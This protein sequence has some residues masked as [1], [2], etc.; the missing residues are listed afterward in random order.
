MLD[1][2]R[3]TH[4]PRRSPCVGDD[5]HVGNRGVDSYRAEL[6]SN[7]IGQRS[8]WISCTRSQSGPVGQCRPRNRGRAGTWLHV[9]RVASAASSARLVTPSLVKMCARCVFTVAR[10]MKSRAPISGLL[11]P[12]A[13]SLT[14]STSVGVR[15]AQP[16]AG[17]FVRRGLATHR[18]RPRRWSRI[19]PRTTQSQRRRRRGSGVPGI[20]PV[21]SPAARLGRGQDRSSP[22][23]GSSAE[24]ADRF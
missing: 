7:R 16:D 14:T 23:G 4:L 8:P 13:V 9:L 3:S 21:R 15:L 18:P 17:A 2:S 5:I 1:P 19:R 10:P 6:D 20:C 12:F 24:E 11:N 22:D